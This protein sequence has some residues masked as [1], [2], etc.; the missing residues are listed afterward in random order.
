MIGLAGLVITPDGKN[1][2][3]ASEFAGGPIGEF[4]R[5]TTTGLLSQ[6]SNS[7]NSD[8]HNCLQEQNSEQDFGCDGEAIGIGSGDQLVVSPDGADLYVAAPSSE[9]VSC[10][11]DDGCSDV[12]EF[13]IDPSTGGL[14]Q[15]ASPDSCIQD[16]TEE[17]SECPNENGTGLGGPGIA[18]SPHGDSVYVTGSD[19]IAEFSRTPVTET[20]TVSLG[21]LRRR[22]GLRRNRRDRLSDDRARTLTR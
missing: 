7:G 22:V 20:L 5:D 19:D 9:A 21:G 2:Y 6:L 16:V 12:A 18:I 17:D 14:V 15:L 3:T 8:A 11:S 13:S 10:S 4:S 1:V